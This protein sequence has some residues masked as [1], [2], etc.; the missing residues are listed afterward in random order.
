MNKVI[1]AIS[2]NRYEV[3]LS[4]DQDDM[5][6]IK[7]VSNILVGASYSECLQDYG[8]AS[9]L[10]DLKVADLECVDG[11][12]DVQANVFTKIELVLADL[13]IEA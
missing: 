3:E 13:K 5:Y 6:Q 8:M 9:Y 4:K 7:Y 2:T 1:K 10:F 11:V 12:N